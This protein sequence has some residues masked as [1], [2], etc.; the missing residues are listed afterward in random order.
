VSFSAN[1]FSFGKRTTERVDQLRRGVTLKLFSAV[2]LDT[3]VDSG[4][5]RANWRVSVGKADLK[6]LPELYDESGQ[7]TIAE[8][9]AAVES[10]KGQGDVT[11]C[12]AN[13]LPYIARLEFDGWSSQAPE[14]MMRKNVTRFVRLLKEEAAKSK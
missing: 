3:P 11:V 13:N 7:A 1:I 8:V 14:G 12:L 6:A 5:A 10:T 4:R 9:G 2:I